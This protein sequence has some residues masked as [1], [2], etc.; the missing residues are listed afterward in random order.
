M[1]PT[2][3]GRSLTIYLWHLPLLVGMSGLLL[4]TP[5]PQPASGTAGWWWA[6]PFV[7]LALVLLLLPIVAAFGRLEDR[8]ATS[9]ATRRRSTPAVAAAV[10]VVFIPVVGAAVNG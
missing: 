6:R 5:I 2:A 7:L 3:G 9:L 1:L 4:L 10:V 8:P